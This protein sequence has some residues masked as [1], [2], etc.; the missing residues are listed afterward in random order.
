MCRSRTVFSR[1]L[2]VRGGSGDV[3]VRLVAV[4]RMA[5]HL[6]GGLGRRLRT[7]KVATLPVAATANGVVG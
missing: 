7:P 1:R 4:L 3:Q 2:R 6:S 5:M